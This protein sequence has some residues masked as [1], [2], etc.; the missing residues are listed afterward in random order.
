MINKNDSGQR[1]DKF[2]TKYLDIPQGI[3]YKSL[4]KNCVRINEKHEKNGSRILNDGDILKLYLKDE[5]FKKPDEFTPSNTELDIIYEDKNIM[6]INKPEG[7]VVHEDDRGTD[8]TL[9]KRIRSYLYVKNE[10][11]PKNEHSFTPSLCNRLDRNTSGLIIAAKNA[12]ALR[13]LNKKIRDREVKKIYV[14]L[15]EGKMEGEGILTSYLKRHEKKVSMSDKF[16]EDSKQTVTKYKVLD[17]DGKIS[18]VEVELET[19][20][21]HQIR[22]QFAK[23]NHPLCGDVK[24]GGSER[25]GHYCLCSCK[26]TFD[27]KTDSG[28]LNY[29]SKKTFTVQP[30]FGL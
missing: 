24:Y 8:D 28:I 20:R 2:L 16:T 27:F 9:I 21:T 19:G 25:D 15:A 1:L 29:L 12:E 26:L 22:A 10:Y 6:I 30:P 14:C 7:L 13:I 11:N 5:F 3:L 23:I 18:M 17:T 4:R